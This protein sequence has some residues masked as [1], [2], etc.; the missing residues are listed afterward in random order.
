MPVLR[1]ALTDA[2]FADVTTYLQ[3]GNVV[4][5]SAASAAKV[6]GEVARLTIADRFGL[7]VAVIVR[8]HTQLAKV[9]DR[10]PLGEL[11]TNPK[12]YL[13]TFL[14]GSSG[15]ATP[16]GRS[17]S[18][19]VDGEQLVRAGRELYTWHPNGKRALEGREAPL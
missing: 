8:T 6:R 16:S 17:S 10:D 11:A 1:E 18:A 19:L 3:S 4:L 9:V 12:L 14:D 2:G 15:S 5:L 13:V 7:D